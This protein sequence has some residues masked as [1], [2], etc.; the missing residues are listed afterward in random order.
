MC[1]KNVQ[2]TTTKM[3]LEQSDEE[4]FSILK[5]CKK[6]VLK[7]T[8][9]LTMNTGKFSVTAGAKSKWMSH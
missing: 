3:D 2:K 6:N 4:G 7:I 1:T 9:K 5:N 8:L